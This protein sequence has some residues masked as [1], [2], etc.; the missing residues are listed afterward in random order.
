MDLAGM[1]ALDELVAAV[2]RDPELKGRKLGRLE[3]C[4]ER[5]NAPAALLGAVRERA[6]GAELLVGGQVVTFDPDARELGRLVGLTLAEATAL[7]DPGATPLVLLGGLP[8]DVPDWLWAHQ[9]EITHWWVSGLPER[10]KAAA[11]PAALGQEA[12]GLDDAA[13]RPALLEKLQNMGFHRAVHVEQQRRGT[14]DLTFLEV[15]VT[16]LADASV[17]RASVGVRVGSGGI[18]APLGVPR[19]DAEPVTIGPVPPPPVA[20]M[21]PRRSTRTVGATPPRHSVTWWTSTG[22]VTAGAGAAVAAGA[23]VYA[24][25]YRP[26]SLGLVRTFQ[27]A[28]V[29]GWVATATGALMVIIPRVRKRSASAPP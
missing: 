9:D 19:R 4:L 21:R 7:A 23:I 24:R 20:R 29:A 6:G 10:S 17:H 3:R 5:R 11:D 2:E 25:A 28:E 15:A 22:L 16:R 1:V 8:E 14:D 27:A 26:S 18:N 13:R 12:I